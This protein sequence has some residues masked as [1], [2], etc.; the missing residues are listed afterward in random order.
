M[1]VEVLYVP[2]CPHRP[3]AIRQL[4]DVLSAE[5]IVAEIHEVAVTD[6]R[7]AEELKFRGSPTIRIN[8]RDI[9]G[10]A[11]RPQSFALTCRL[12]PGAKEA[13]VPPVEMI[14]HAV[15]EAREGEKE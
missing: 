2:E 10:E 7:T 5:G 8:G 4:G 1:R 14:Q 13:G 6:A 12:Y 11:S 15:R 9:A 3:A